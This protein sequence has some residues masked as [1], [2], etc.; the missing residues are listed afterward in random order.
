MLAET[1]QTEI[2]DLKSLDLSVMHCVSEA[3]EIGFYDRPQRGRFQRLRP[4]L[5]RIHMYL[6]NPV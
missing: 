5:L 2:D 6:R 3:T 1:E 4:E